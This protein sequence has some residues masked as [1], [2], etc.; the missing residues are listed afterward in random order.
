[1]TPSISFLAAALL[2]SSTAYGKITRVVRRQNP[3]LGFTSRGCFSE[4]T[5]ARALVGN[6]YFDDEMTL[7]KCAAFCDGYSY[8]GAEFGRECYVST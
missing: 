3:G 6:D 2:L 4:A 5:T 8:F 7:E 1:M